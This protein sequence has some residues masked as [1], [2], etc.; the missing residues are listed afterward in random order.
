M[1]RREKRI[2]I[3]TVCTG[4]LCSLFFA[5]QDIQRNLSRA[6]KQ[7]RA[8]Q[9]C[10]SCNTE[11][12]SPYRSNHGD[13]VTGNS[14]HLLLPFLKTIISDYTNIGNH[15]FKSYSLLVRKTFF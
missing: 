10:A 15:V 9:R 2:K 5:K 1:R 7:N 12:C 6:G 4:H 14:D 3:F 13:K 11:P 8:K